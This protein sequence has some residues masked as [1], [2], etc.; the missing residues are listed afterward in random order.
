MPVRIDGRVAASLELFRARGAFRLGEREAARVAAAQVAL[1]L[2][3][4]VNGAGTALSAS[5]LMLTAEALAA[6]GDEARGADRIARLAADATGAS[7]ALLWR[8]VGEGIAPL[9]AAG[10]VDRDDTQPF[11]DAVF[12]AR[13][14]GV[15][16]LEG[17]TVVSLPLGQPPLGVLQLLFPSG[18]VPA[19]PSSRGSPPLPLGRRRRCGRSNARTSCAASSSALATYSQSSTRRRPSSR[20]PTRWRP[21]SMRLPRLLDVRS[22][23]IYLR[24]HGRF[25]TAAAAEVRAARG[26][27]R[28]S[29]RPRARAVPCAR[30]RRV[31][32]RGAD[33]HLAGVRAAV[34]EAG[35]R[36][37]PRRAA[38]RPGRGDRPAR[39]STRRT[40]GL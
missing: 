26:R 5:A 40:A 31:H 23:G 13:S 20:S 2:R 9:A 33:R 27:R 32:G 8:A 22:V 35:D 25:E 21:Q 34:Q 29:A 30:V 16:W 3:S 24:Q 19:T 4:E 18:T 37:R 1:V 17:A 39:R 15:D 12:S 6:G 28:A 36:G 14:P 38:G 11:A 7:A 10:T